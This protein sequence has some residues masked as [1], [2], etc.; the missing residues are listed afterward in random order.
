[1]VSEL[2]KILRPPEPKA[3]PDL[4]KKKNRGSLIQGIFTRP[5]IDKIQK[6]GNA[7]HKKVPN[8]MNSG[9]ERDSTRLGQRGLS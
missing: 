5:R 8:S 1:M 9:P 7:C 4:K 2:R 6:R 3:I